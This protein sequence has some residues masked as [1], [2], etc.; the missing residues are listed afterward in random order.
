MPMEFAH[1][2]VN[3]FGEGGRIRE[4]LGRVRV[5]VVPVVNVD[6]FIV[7]RT[8]GATPAD[9]NSTATLPLSLVDALSYKRK[10]CRPPADAPAN[11]PCVARPVAIGV[12]PNRNYGAYWGGVGSSTTYTEQS[13]RGTGPFSE[14]ETEA[15]H[16]LSSR[17]HPT[18]VIS[19]H[20]FTAGGTWL[21]QPGFRTF[22]NTVPDEA[23]MKSLGDAMGA[24][25]GWASQLG[26]AIGDITGATED[27]NYFA[28][29]SLGYTP[30]GRGPNFHADYATVVVNEYV[31]TRAGTQG[32]VREAY[33]RA[34]ERAASPADHSVITGTAPPGAKLRLTKSFQT[35]TCQP[36]CFTPTLFVNDVLDTR[37]T[38]P[39]SGAYEWHVNQSSRPFVPGEA[40]TMT[41]QIPGQDE[42]TTTVEVARGESVTVDWR[43]GA[44]GNEPP[45]ARFGYTPPAPRA[46]DE[47]AFTSTSTD[48][49]N[50][51]ASYEWDLDADGEYDDGDAPVATHTFTAPGTYAVSLRV[52]DAGGL[53][54][55]ATQDVVVAE[56][57]VNAL[58]VAAFDF[59]PLRPRRGEMVTFRSTSTDSDGP[60]VAHDWDLDG[61]RAFDDATGAQVTHV[62]HRSGRQTVSLRVTDRR[63][64]TA[65]ASRRIDVRGGGNRD[66]DNRDDRDRDDRDRDD[67]D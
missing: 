5:I 54:A 11:V 48:P 33:L 63:G 52:T 64:A 7:S 31:G 23:P 15:I 37:L 59:A 42:F 44:C 55:T 56:A 9:G 14:P 61:D 18:V 3:G 21:R 4:I 39:Q 43:G 58:P 32:G 57:P 22:G 10:T 60:I 19:N 50:A 27:W 16:R 62:F 65:V 24:A 51:I 20:T 47:V 28:Q 8:F 66:R 25:S 13:Y 41:C 1:D 6:G 53:T 30:E 40:W 49:E 45:E 46:W 67:D 38:A 12:D 34:A 35:P 29:G 26:W 36:N 17:L 2:L